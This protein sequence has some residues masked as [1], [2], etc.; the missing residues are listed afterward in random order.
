[1]AYLTYVKSTT[2]SW[3][4]SSADLVV[5]GIF[6]DQT[7][8]SNGNEINIHLNNAV[9][10]GIDCGGIKGKEGECHKFF[11]ENKRYLLLGLGDKEKFNTESMRKA[12]GSTAK[13]A[14][15]EK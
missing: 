9:T 5:F 1:M 15:K 10:K 13:F 8:T 11:G 14:L 4:K 7:M 6:K 3:T 12:G 2:A